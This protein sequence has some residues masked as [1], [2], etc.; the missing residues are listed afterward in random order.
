ML[1]QKH[2]IRNIM[3]QLIK[4]NYILNNKLNSELNYVFT[5]ISFEL[6]SENKINLRCGE[7]YLFNVH[8]IRWDRACRLTNTQC[9]VPM[10]PPQVSPALKS[11][12][13][14]AKSLH[15][16]VLHCSTAFLNGKLLPRTS[17]RGRPKATPVSTKHWIFST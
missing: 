15:Y 6:V 4:T 10:G 17:V 16:S 8:I 9:S 12:A 3:I 2:N 7:I 13:F 5:S 11:K 1:K 14:P